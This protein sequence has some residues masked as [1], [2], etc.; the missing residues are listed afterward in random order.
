M[1]AKVSPDLV[2]GKEDICQYIGENISYFDVLRVC[3]KLP[4]WQRVKSGT[5]F[6]LKSKL[7]IWL[8]EQLERYK[9]NMVN[10]YQTQAEGNCN[11]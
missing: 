9:T 2:K 11:E 7:D 6:S 3:D 8:T 10:P 5:W 4:V 1:T